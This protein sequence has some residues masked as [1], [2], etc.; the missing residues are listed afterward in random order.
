MESADTIKL[1]IEN[2]VC[3]VHGIA[4]VVDIMGNELKISCCCNNF[5]QLCT[6]EAIS[7]FMLK[8]EYPY[9]VLQE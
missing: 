1:I 3:P 4:P 5:H 8:K 2:Q 6:K 7:F 9:W